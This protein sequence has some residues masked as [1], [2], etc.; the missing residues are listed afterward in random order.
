MLKRSG[1]E[2]EF[3]KLAAIQEGRDK[4]TASAHVFLC[5]L[6]SGKRSFGVYVILALDNRGLTFVFC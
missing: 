1:E 6:L 5:S 3:R 2:T 4:K